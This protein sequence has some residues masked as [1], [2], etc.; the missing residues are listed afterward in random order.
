M[1]PQH[2]SSFRVTLIEVLGQYW[3]GS[4]KVT[5]HRVS[6]PVRGSAP[7][8]KCGSSQRIGCL[9]CKRLMMMNDVYALE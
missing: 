3:A 1:L 4:S 2:C 9:G 8:L 7:D 6:E 5:R